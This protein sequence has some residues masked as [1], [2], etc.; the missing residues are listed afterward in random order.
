MRFGG[1]KAG[2]AL[3]ACV[4]VAGACGGSP[5]GVETSD[6]TVPTTISASEAVVTETSTVATSGNQGTTGT[7]V[8]TSTSVAASTATSASVAT[9]TSTSTSVAASTSTSTSVATST[10]TS[11]S[12]AA[13]TATSTSVAPTSTIPSDDLASGG[14]GNG[15]NLDSGPHPFNT[16]DPNLRDCLLRGFGADL[17]EELSGGRQP[18][19]AEGEVIGF[20][21]SAGSSADAGPQPAPAEEPRP[22]QGD[23]PDRDDGP[24]APEPVT[25]PTDQG[26]VSGLGWITEVNRLMDAVTLGHSPVADVLDQS[27]G[28]S[29]P[30]VVQLADGTYRLYFA[31]TPDGLTVAKSNDGV[32]WELE[33]RTVIP[34]G[35]PHT[36]MV[37]LAD[38]G[39]RLFA[40][41]NVSGGSVVKSFV[42]TDGLEFT[43]EPGDRLTNED[44][45]F[46]NIQSPFAFEMPDGSFRMYLT[47]YPEGEQAAQP[48]GYSVLRMVSA[49]SD[50]ML[51]WSTDPGVVIEGL[52]HPSVVVSDD[53]TITVYA[54]TPFTKL[55]STDG[56][57]FSQPEYL[58]LSG[59]DFDVKLMATGQLRVYSNGHDF[60]EGSWLRISRSTTVTWDAEISVRGYDSINDV[61]TLD[62]CVTGSS[63]TP[64]EVHL[65][66]KDHR[67]RK[68]DFESSSVSVAQGVPPFRTTITLDD[69]G[70][71]G[72]PYDWRP[73]KSMLRLFDGVTIREWAIDEV[74][75]DQYLAASK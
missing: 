60:D 31:A 2:S 41:K 3:L 64:I 15:V 65:T 42:S 49:T 4:L 67:I 40:V 32:N 54:G 58:D 8:T 47:A 52:D 5:T 7:T 30:R 37:S 75:T 12:V 22:A 19:A 59:R 35:M 10:S 56:R 50:D 16:T 53:G 44:F 38:G 24:A 57:Q 61:F 63:A 39:W 45:P 33:A 46:G 36:S 6:P 11:T 74:F 14:T 51:S 25:C 48:N 66:D 29:D 69:G 26:P 20:C 62:V 55:V 72:G 70:V 9:S 18:N 28:A 68:L 1:V 13:S 43:E 34:S 21:L 71:P 73:T 27:I 17:F 23:G